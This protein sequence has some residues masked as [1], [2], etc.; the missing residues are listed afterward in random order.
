MRVSTC[1]VIPSRQR[2]FTES[3][4]G[5][6]VVVQRAAIGP[7]LLLA[8]ALGMIMR[9]DVLKIGAQRVLFQIGSSAPE[10]IP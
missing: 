1:G 3:G 2:R 5:A 8:I 6:I 10:K 4:R 7:H 9:D